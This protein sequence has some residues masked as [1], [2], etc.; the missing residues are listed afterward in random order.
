MRR[1]ASEKKEYTSTG[2]G[3]HGDQHEHALSSCVHVVADRG[4]VLLRP[5]QVRVALLC[6][7]GRA[8]VV[9][10]GAGACVQRTVFL[11]SLLRRVQKVGWK[12]GDKD[13]AAG[14]KREW[15]NEVSL[16]RSAQI[17]LSLSLRAQHCVGPRFCQWLTAHTTCSRT[18]GRRAADSFDSRQEGEITSPDEAI[19]CTAAGVPS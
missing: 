10:V 17:L 2:F 18:S 14:G 4:D 19:D 9:G 8:L 12:K 16:Q 6:N 3:E 7:N 13:A 5:E 1:E 11:G 15:Q